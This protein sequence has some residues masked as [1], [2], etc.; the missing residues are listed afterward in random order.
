MYF[1]QDSK[2][3]REMNI[4]QVIYDRIMKS[5]I[6]TIKNETDTVLL[7]K[8]LHKCVE[9][10]EGWKDPS[11]WNKIDDI[12]DEICRRLS[13]EQDRNCSSILFLFIAKITT[14]PIKQQLMIQKATDFTNL[15][16]ISNLKTVELNELRQVCENYINLI[17]CRWIKKLKEMI[18]NQKLFGQEAHVQLR[19][20]KFSAE[21]VIIKYKL[22]LFRNSSVQLSIEN[23]VE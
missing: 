7:L 6:V 17:S 12:I 15:T 20:R 10:D 3:I 8:C 9:T 23:R 19:V 1:I 5:L 22:K 11:K 2:L 13:L 18:L 21:I 16:L 4:H 14:L